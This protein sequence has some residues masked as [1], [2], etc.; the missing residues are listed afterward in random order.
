ML[1]RL[2]QGPTGQ[3]VPMQVHA[4]T[5]STKVPL[6]RTDLALQEVPSIFSIINLLL[7][8][9]ESHSLLVH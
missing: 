4:L 9:P 6:D 8:S 7:E 1:H 5:V 3:G 2:P